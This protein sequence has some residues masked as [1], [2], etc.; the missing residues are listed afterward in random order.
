MLKSSSIRQEFKRARRRSYRSY[1]NYNIKNK[2][3]R[4][5]INK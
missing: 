4:L 5:T 3:L 2:L 1:I